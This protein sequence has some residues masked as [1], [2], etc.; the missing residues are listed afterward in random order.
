MD[1][2]V[3]EVDGYVIDCMRDTELLVDIGRSQ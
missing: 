1:L 3:I 2:I